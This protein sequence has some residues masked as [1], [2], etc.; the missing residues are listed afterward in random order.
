[1]GKEVRTF[2]GKMMSRAGVCSRGRGREKRGERE[3]EREREVGRQLRRKM[4][5]MGLPLTVLAV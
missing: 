4:V 1:M 2:G 5:I 3:R